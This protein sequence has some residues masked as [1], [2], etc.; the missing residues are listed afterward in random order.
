[1]LVA[2]IGGDEFAV[3][4]AADAIDAAEVARATARTLTAGPSPVSV[5]CGIATS[6]GGSVRAREL[7][8]LADAAQH[9]AKAQGRGRIAVARFPVLHEPLAD[10]ARAPFRA[11]RDRAW[12]GQ[13]R[14]LDEV[15][16]ALDGPLRTAEALERLAAV[17]EAAAAALRPRRWTV[18][19]VPGVLDVVPVLEGA[20]LRDHRPEATRATPYPLAGV[21]PAHLAVTGE[22]AVLVRAHDADPG[23][24]DELAR[25]GC[26][27]VLLAGAC[28]GG[29]GYLLELFTDPGGYDLASAR[30]AIRLLVG[31][32]VHRAVTP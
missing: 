16:D 28:S 17:A 26:D 13:T 18:S 2:R 32:A 4:L 21:V 29:H 25:L 31:E 30:S 12:D 11:Y 20:L 23:T 14:L 5:S 24:A 9:T 27:Q 7:L 1:V 8:R 19:E 10:D 22:V 6:D 3:V 15:L